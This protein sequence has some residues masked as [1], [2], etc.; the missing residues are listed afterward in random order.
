MLKDRTATAALWMLVDT[1]GSQGLSFAIYAVLTRI[2]SPGEYGVFS[3]SLA[4]TAVANIVLFQGFG[5]ALIQRESVNEDDLCTA[6]WTNL[7]LGAGIAAVLFAMAPW[8][9]ATFGAPQLSPVI[10]SM[11]LLC[12]LRA[13]VSVHSALCRRAL[14]MS[15]FAARAI[16]AYVLGGAVGITLALLGWGVWSLVV[17][18][19]VQAAVIVIIMWMT[20]SWRPQLRF[21][22]S[23][24]GELARFSRHFITASVLTSVADKV[25]NLVIGFFLD[26]TAVGYYA[27]ALKVLQTVG[28][29]TMIPLQEIILPVLARVATDRNEFGNVYTRLVTAAAA[30]SVPMT[31]G[32]G[33]VAPTLLPIA[34]GNH[35]SDAVPVLQAMCFACVT[36]PLW[37][38]TGQALSALGRPNLYARLALGQLAFAAVAFTAASQ[39]GIV[40]VG[41]AWAG[42]SA[43]IVPLHLATLRHSSGIELTRLLTNLLRVAICGLA[44]V[45]VMILIQRAA[46]DGVWAMWGEIAAGSAIY[47]ALLELALMPGYV[48]SMTRLARAALPVFGGT[49]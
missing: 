19:I 10:G 15:V 42:V 32:I 47:L 30:T 2:L 33:V 41:W 43:L 7:G 11:A 16:T 26:V 25:D 4:I 49:R 46:G 35:W 44:M 31:A 22:V 37:N 18:Q 29:L 27:L 9:G 21:S 12:V 40:A 48:S 39:L 8:L 45:G 13:L 5:D 24:F 20:I 36:V 1:V 23:S 38:F 14:K 17:C 3:L 6:F 34:F 28:F